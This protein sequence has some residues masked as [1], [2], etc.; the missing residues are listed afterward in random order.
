M[1]KNAGCKKQQLAEEL[2]QPLSD[3]PVDHENEGGETT[4]DKI[5]SEKKEETIDDIEVVKH[6]NY[7]QSLVYAIVTLMFV[8]SLI[9]N[10]DHGAMPAALRDIS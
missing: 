4:T 8:L 3:N 1:Y 9:S 7:S 5:A 6:L 2:L 10:M